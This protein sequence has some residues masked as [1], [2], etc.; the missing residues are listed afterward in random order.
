MDSGKI[1]SLF[2]A[3]PAALPDSNWSCIKTELFPQAIHNVPFS[4]KMQPV[5]TGCKNHKSGWIRFDL[6]NVPNPKFVLA[7][8]GL[9]RFRQ[10]RHKHIVQS[11][12]RDP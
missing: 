12:G 8:P 4:R 1:M 10:V 9:E 6:C 3:K 11:T 5:A 7:I 2:L